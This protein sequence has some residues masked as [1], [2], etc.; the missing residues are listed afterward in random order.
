MQ[1][2]SVIVKKTEVQ[3]I[4]ERKFLTLFVISANVPDEE[5]YVGRAEH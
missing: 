4:L 1:A 3:E 5:R 2:E